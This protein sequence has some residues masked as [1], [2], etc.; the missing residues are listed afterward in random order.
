MEN[1]MKYLVFIILLLVVT[2]FKFSNPRSVYA[3]DLDTST[4]VVETIK[5]KTR[6]GYKVVSVTAYDTNTEFSDFILIMEK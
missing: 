4:Q 6:E 1:K 2:S 3:V 5:S